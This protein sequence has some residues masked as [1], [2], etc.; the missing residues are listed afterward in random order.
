MKKLVLFSS[1]LAFLAFSSVGHAKITCPSEYNANQYI[2]ASCGSNCVAVYSAAPNDPANLGETFIVPRNKNQ[3]VTFSGIGSSETFRN[4]I[5]SIVMD[6]AVT[7][8]TSAAFSNLSGLESVKLSNSITTIPNSAFQGANFKSIE[9]PASV[10]QL[11]QGILG[12]ANP[13]KIEKVTF[14][15]GSQIQTIGNNVFAGSQY[16]KEIVIPDSV[17]TIGQG[18]FQSCPLLETI[19]FGENSQ[20]Q[21]IGKNAFVGSTNLKEIILPD[22]LNFLDVQSSGLSADVK[23]YCQE[24]SK[25]SKS[26]HDLINEKNPWFL[27]KLVL[28]TEDEE[29]N[30]LPYSVDGNGNIISGGKVYSSLSKLEKGIDIKR[31]YTVE[32]ASKVSKDTGNK[33]M[34]RYK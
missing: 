5:S 22:S 33:I 13:S 20:I 19:T 4:Y 25:R 7:A 11:G 1:F 28:F 16:L 30:M 12:S 31:I 18:A 34:L 2:C 32:E 21:T 15:E 14:A 27:S 8:V 3:A 29:G 23:I 9:I 26:C 6:N 10:T 24:S 17:Q